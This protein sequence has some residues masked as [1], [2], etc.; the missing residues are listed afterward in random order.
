[1]KYDLRTRNLTYK[2]L[3]F[4]FDEIINDLRWS[5]RNSLEFQMAMVYIAFLYFFRMFNHYVGQ[6]FACTI[7]GVPV[8]RYDTHW[9]KIYLEYAASTF[10]QE[11][12]IVASGILFN[13]LVFVFGFGL[14]L[15]S[16]KCC[17]CFPRIYYK[18]ISWIGVFTMLD[19]I[20]V[21]LVDICS[22]SFILGDWFKLYHYY[23]VKEN[24]GIV[25]MYITFF[26]MFSLT[27]F[28]GFLFYYYM[29][30][31]HMNGRILDLYKRISGTLKSFF[32]PNDSE[33]SLRYL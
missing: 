15:V 29:I 31:I 10:M 26:I 8:T 17:S 1:M 30:F 20:F 9:Y 22:Q 13:T 28:N 25:G 2:K 11:V 5:K 7:M 23:L 33:V 24:S 19:P 32:V 21:L 6:F 4:I 18:I 12:I 16:K 14:A 27:I 3:K